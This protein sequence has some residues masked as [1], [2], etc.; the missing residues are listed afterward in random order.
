MLEKSGGYFETN[1][2][3]TI[4]PLVLDVDVFDLFEVR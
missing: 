3:I 2:Q 1:E 4:K